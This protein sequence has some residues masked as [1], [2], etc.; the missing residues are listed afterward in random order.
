[1]PVTRPCSALVQDPWAA[2]Y[3]PAERDWE[4]SAPSVESGEV[5]RWAVDGRTQTVVSLGGPR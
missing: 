1:M 3:R 4:V 5:L 2:D